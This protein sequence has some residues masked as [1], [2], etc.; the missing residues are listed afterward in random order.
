MR[1]DGAR[2]GWK[3]GEGSARGWKRSPVPELYLLRASLALARHE[4]QPGGLGCS[5]RAQKSREQRLRVRAGGEITGAAPH[6]LACQLQEPTNREIRKVPDTDAEMAPS[7]CP[8]TCA[9]PPAW[10][11]RPGRRRDFWCFS[12]TRVSGNE[13]EHLTPQPR[14]RDPLY[15]E[16][17][18]QVRSPL[19]PHRSAATLFS[20][21]I[22]S[23][24][25]TRRAGRERQDPRPR[26]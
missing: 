2:R 18:D 13:R 14:G 23:T 15:S 22:A 7:H 16:H 1:G 26:T 21:G 3:G 4:L 6:P 9:F 10:T 5:G 11:A 12:L 24:R 20:P 17:R 19:D 25:P 8:Q